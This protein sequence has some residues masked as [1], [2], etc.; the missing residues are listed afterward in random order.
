MCGDRTRR[1]GWRGSALQAAAIIALVGGCGALPAG[2]TQ[3]PPPRAAAQSTSDDP[4]RFYS[5]E[6][7]GKAFG[8]A[9]K[10]SKLTNVCDYRGPG[11]DRVVVQVKAGAEGTIL[12]H[13]RSASAQSG[14]GAEK[15][16]MAVGEAYFDSV[17]PVFIGRVGD[18]EVQIESTIQPIPRD[19][20]IAVGR[21]I[22]EKLARK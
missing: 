8:R 9:M 3:T 10:S 21:S 4:C 16:Q 12:R 6:A 2:Q 13:A 17:I 15:V 20:M 19:T 18:H 22:M 14:S 1:L 5:D 7:M 11:T